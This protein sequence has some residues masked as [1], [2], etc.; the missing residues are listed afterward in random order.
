MKIFKLLI[1]LLAVVSLGAC[2]K[3]EVGF[4]EGGDRVHFKKN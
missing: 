2:K 1:L 4:Y 3:E